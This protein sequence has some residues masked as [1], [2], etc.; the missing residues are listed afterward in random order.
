[1]LS[2]T[3]SVVMVTVDEAAAAVAAAAAGRPPK[4]PPNT[5]SNRSEAGSTGS[6]AGE[7]RNAANRA[8]GKQ[9]MSM[10]VPNLPSSMEQT[11]SL[12]ESFAAVARRNLGNATNNMARSNNASSLVRLA[13][14][15]NSPSKCHPTG[16]VIPP[17]GA[18][19][20]LL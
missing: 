6:A 9:P 14:S 12:L 18:A 2:L 17:P 7:A 11:V 4:T 1:M 20:T 5:Q 13:L 19:G 10:S 16:A 15:S 8:D 3:D